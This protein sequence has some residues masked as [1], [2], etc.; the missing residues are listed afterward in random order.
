MCGGD[1]CISFHSVCLLVCEQVVQV[2]EGNLN[3]RKERELSY[4]FIHPSIHPS[5][6]KDEEAVNNA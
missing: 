5:I 1:D 4:S 2:V 6:I 3:G